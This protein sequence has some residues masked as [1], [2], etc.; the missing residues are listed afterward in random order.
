MCKGHFINE[1]L[2]YYDIVIYVILQGIIRIFL[3]GRIHSGS[4]IKMSEAILTEEGGGQIS[5][6]GAH[7]PDMTLA[8]AEALK[9]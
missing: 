7:L 3:T 1:R 4:G 5:I 8:V 2:L 9:C 6:A